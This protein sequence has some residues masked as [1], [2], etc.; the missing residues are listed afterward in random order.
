MSIRAR[1]V[2]F[3]HVTSMLISKHAHARAH[4]NPH[5]RIQRA[6]T[7]LHVHLAPR[8]HIRLHPHT[9]AS[10]QALTLPSRHTAPVGYQ[11]GHAM[12]TRTFLCARPEQACP[13]Q[14]P[15]AHASLT[16]VYAERVRPIPRTLT[17]AP[18]L[19]ISVLFP[20]IHSHHHVGIHNAS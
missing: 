18:S 4:P 12:P 17:P 5:A 13:T 10:I 15:C 3:L 16:P 7:I 11:H 6:H 2:P 1:C 8:A 20:Q 14:D 19:T 9:P